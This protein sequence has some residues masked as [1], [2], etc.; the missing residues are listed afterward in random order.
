MLP[1]LKSKLDSFS[2]SARDAGTEPEPSQ[3]QHEQIHSLFVSWAKPSFAHE[4]LDDA[5]ASAANPQP[6]DPALTGWIE[7]NLSF[8]TTQAVRPPVEGRMQYLPFI[9][10]LV[11]VIAAN[12]KPRD[13]VAFKQAYPGFGALIKRSMTRVSLLPRM[14][15]E[16]TD[17]AAFFAKRP[18]LKNLSLNQLGLRTPAA[19][20][21]CLD[22]IPL[23]VKT[24]IPGLNLSEQPL[25]GVSIVDFQALAELNISGSL[26]E[27]ATFINAAAVREFF[28]RIA[29]AV[30]DSLVNFDLSWL[31]LD[32]VRLDGFGGLKKLILVHAE[33][34]D[35][36]AVQTFL[37]SIPTKANI[38]ELDLS[39]LPLGGVRLVGFGGLKKL[40]LSRADFPD[41]AAVQAFL[42]SIPKEGKASISELDL[43]G[44]PLDG[45]RLTGFPSLEKLSLSRA[46]FTDVDAVQAFLDCVST[47]AKITDLDLSELLSVSDEDATADGLNLG[48]FSWL[49]KLNL[50]GV[51]FSNPWFSDATALQAVLDS[52]SASVTDLNLSELCLDGLRLG[53]FDRL[54]KLNLQQAL[55][56]RPAS[57]Q[58]LLNSLSTKAKDSMSDLNLFWLPLAGV[59]LVD[60]KGL[61]KL[62]VGHATF[63]EQGAAVELQSFLNDISAKTKEI[64]VDLDLSWLRLDDISLVDLPKLDK[65]TFSNASFSNLNAQQRFLQHVA[66]AN[67]DEVND[68]NLQLDEDIDALFEFPF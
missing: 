24:G 58:A 12:L 2:Q 5:S 47:E 6:Q 67:I 48:G 22:R 13:L 11:P 26:F 29:S 21:A 31:P 16:N 23:G 18:Y 14:L 36:A 33:F 60:F 54:K 35:A 57:T 34:S 66:A 19:V 50:A 17:W 30:K 27:G 65:L 20:Q 39:G 3:N 43:S 46:E 8:L 49:E 59:K 1:V 28:V 61:A 63:S 44:L 68:E 55:L 15:T 40:G 53:R 41:A 10:D 9:N 62:D 37:D 56:S 25:S 42:D 4:T 32:G 52:T 45:V 7:S 51:S 38:T 64:L